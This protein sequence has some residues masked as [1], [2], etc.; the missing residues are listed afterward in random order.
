MVLAGGGGM[1]GS[2][3]AGGGGIPGSM[4]L[5]ARVGTLTLRLGGPKP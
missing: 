2:K 5:L 4:I 3:L 1:L